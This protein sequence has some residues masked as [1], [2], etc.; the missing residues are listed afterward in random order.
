MKRNLKTMLAMGQN[1][2]A[3]VFVIAASLAFTGCTKN[4]EKFNSNPNS[5]SPGQSISIASTAFGPIE[6][7][8]YSNYQIAQNLSAD[9]YAG[10]MMS[11]TN[12][13]GGLN[14]LKY[15]LVDGW[16]LTGFN[17]E[18]N[19]VMSPVNQIA[20]A[21]AR[22]A[23]PDLWAVALLIQVEAMDRV[24]DRFGPIPYTKAG[25]SLTNIPYDS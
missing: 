12:F 19:L 8:I 21:G 11:P 6:Q 7:A 2:L 4:F 15:S 17:D 16:N 25:S 10:Y 18:Y 9:A 13:R 3:G 5:L 20:K 23:Q 22:T 14:N 1:R 24:T